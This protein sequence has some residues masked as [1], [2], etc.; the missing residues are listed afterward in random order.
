[1][2]CT[3]L[4]WKHFISVDLNHPLLNTARFAS[5]LNGHL[6]ASAAAI[7]WD[8][9]EVTLNCGTNWEKLEVHSAPGE[10]GGQLQT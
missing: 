5:V 10:L 8:E 4:K 6:E 3:Y 7:L 2:P 1:M 9:A